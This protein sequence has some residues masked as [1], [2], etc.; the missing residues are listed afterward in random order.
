M[1]MKRSVRI[2]KLKEA[3]SDLQRIEAK[4]TMKYVRLSP[5]KARVVANRIKTMSID[6]AV[7]TLTFM[8]NKAAR[9]IKKTLDSAIANGV[10]NFD[11]D[12]DSLYIKS[13]II[14]E[15][16]RLKRLKTRGMGRADI[17]YTKLSHITVV[18]GDSSRNQNVSENESE[19]N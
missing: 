15:G 1:A 6:N 12:P 11:F 9:Y 13:I 16:P 4:A 18:I 3:T 19:V 10:N 17:Q 14:D 8:K 5:R 2:R 7:S